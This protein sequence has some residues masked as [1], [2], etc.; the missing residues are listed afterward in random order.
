VRYSFYIILPIFLVLTIFGDA[1]M[2]FWMGQRYANRLLLAI[3]MVGYLAAIVQ[4]PVLNILAGLNAHG[5]AGIARFIASLCSVGLAILALEYFRWGLIGVALAVTLPLTV[6]NVTYLAR[7]VCK[8]VGLSMR[9]YFLSVL[10]GPI[11]HVLPFAICLIVARFAFQTK[12]MTGLVWG[13]IAGGVIL[14][15]L[16][17]RY[18]LPDRLRLKVSNLMGVPRAI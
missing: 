10:I 17:Y 7:L 12:L 16:Y 9:Y 13:G 6:M 5:R 8:Q 15:V 3:L 18:V 2:Q 1:V 11:I 14:A 4:L